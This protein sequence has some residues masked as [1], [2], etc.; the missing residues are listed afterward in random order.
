MMAKVYDIA[1]IR[2]KVMASDDIQYDEV[3]VEEW[4][5]TLPVKTLSASEM[6]E[7][8]K[9]DKDVIRM[10]IVA[11]LNGC[12]TKDGEAVFKQSDLAKFEK[13]KSLG[14]IS[15]VAERIMQMSGMS[16]GAVKEAK[17]G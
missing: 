3:Y 15:K 1:A 16:D 11:I 8:Q 14:A 6:K 9:Y 5:V 12:K 7:V 10:M 17:N 4:D 2:E 13:D